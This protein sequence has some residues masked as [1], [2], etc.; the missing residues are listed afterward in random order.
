MPT[1]FRLFALALTLAL[2]AC[3]GRH[4]HDT[5]SNDNAHTR[6]GVEVYGDMNVGVGSQRVR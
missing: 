3:A 4:A 2:S 5:S 6:S 1:L